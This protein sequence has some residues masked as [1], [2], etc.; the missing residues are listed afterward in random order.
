MKTRPTH[1]I[2]SLVAIMLAASAGV[3]DAQTTWTNFLRQRQVGSGVE[4]QVE[5]GQTGSRPALLPLEAQG[6]DFQIW[7]LKSGAGNTPVLLDTKFVNAYQLASTIQIV[8]AD[9]YQVIPRTRVDQPFTVRVNV[10]GLQT[11]TSRMR[12]GW[13][14]CGMTWRHCRRA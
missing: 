13:W 14:R 5:V 2:G 11:G 3:A 8:T 7:T 4:L 12:P 9:P 10:A 1:A 6:A